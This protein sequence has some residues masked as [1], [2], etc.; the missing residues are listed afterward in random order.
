MKITGATTCAE[1]TGPGVGRNILDWGGFWYGEGGTYPL[2]YEGL[3]D[4]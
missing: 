2:A 1:G 4:S 3:N